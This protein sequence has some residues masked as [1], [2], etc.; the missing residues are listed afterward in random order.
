MCRFSSGDWSVDTRIAKRY[1]VFGKKSS[2]EY[3]E[4]QLIYPY[5]DWLRDFANG[6]CGGYHQTDASVRSGK[7]EGAEYNKKMNK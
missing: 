3:G 2:L 1:V 6:L 4:R 5:Y 7:H